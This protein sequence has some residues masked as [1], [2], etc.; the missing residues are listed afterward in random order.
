VRVDRRGPIALWTLDRPERL[1][2]LSRAVVR[3]IGA[4]AEQ[5]A[6]DA[7]TRVVIVTGAGDRA[8]CA[9]ADLEER[10]DMSEDDVR[11][12]LSLYRE[13]FGRIDRL[14]KPVI[15]AI[16]GV[17]LGGGLE[18]ALCC[19]LRVIVPDA[20]V[21]LT[22]TA[23]AIIP[24][25]GGTQRLTRLVGPG[26]AKELILLARRIDATEARA[27]GLVNRVAREGQSAVDLALELAQPLAEGAPVALAAALE[28]I[29]A[30]TE[31][32]LEKGLDVERRCY[33]RTLGTADRLEALA[34]FREK[35]PPRF[36]GS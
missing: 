10:Q 1:N 24:G 3:R 30:A 8:F 34:A 9:G 19:D 22:E 31:L 12:I 33:E 18:L 11:E 23:L 26:V 28:A 2:A 21:G 4:L 5:A 6:G 13:S 7:A 27:L 32:R 29:D 25:A 15:A 16:N 20:V 14:D 17:A 35:R 36:R